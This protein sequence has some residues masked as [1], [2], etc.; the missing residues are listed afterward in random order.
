MSEAWNIPLAEAHIES[1]VLM[2]VREVS[3]SRCALCQVCFKGDQL[4]LGVHRY[5]ELLH[6]CVDLEAC[7]NRRLA[8]KMMQDPK[9]MTTEIE[10]MVKLPKTSTET[11]DPKHA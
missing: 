8:E 7:Q 9:K 1:L 10:R 4:S 6:V 11:K 3:E 2:R 5:G